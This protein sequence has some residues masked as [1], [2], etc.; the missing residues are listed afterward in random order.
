MKRCPQLQR[1][2]VRQPPVVPSQYT[3]R[4]RCELARGGENGQVYGQYRSAQYLLPKGL[5]LK[6][7]IE[8]TN[9]PQPYEVTW[10]IQNSGDEAAAAGQLRWDRNQQDCWTS[11]KFKGT[12]RMT[13]EVKRHGNVVAV[14]HHF[15]RIRGAGRR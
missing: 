7:S 14:A 1:A 11:T 4:L 9:V 12:H 2:S 15:I 5:G 13:C 3:L 6:F 10:R 8:S